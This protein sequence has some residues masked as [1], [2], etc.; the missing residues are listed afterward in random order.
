VQLVVFDLDGTITRHDTLVP[1]VVRLLVRRP[2]QLMRL[3]GAVPALLLFAIGRADHGRVKAALMKATLRG[4]RRSELEAWTHDF[5]TRLLAKGVHRRALDV[6]EQH[7]R[8]GDRLVLLSASPDLYV[9]AIARALGFDE[10]ISTGVRWNDDRFDGELVTPNRRGQEKA[11]CVSEL[12]HRHPGV[13]IFAYANGPADLP[14]LKL[15][16]RPLLVNGLPVTRRHAQ[17][18]GIPTASWR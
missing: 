12:R 17:R 13:T 15:V 5:V 16:D 11:H 10:A 7:R 8:K 9:P 1:Y 6:I 14:H 2:W 18:L 3:I 4:R